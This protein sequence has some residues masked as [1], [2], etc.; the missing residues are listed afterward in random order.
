MTKKKQEKTGGRQP[1]EKMQVVRQVTVTPTTEAHIIA[2]SL[3]RV[4]GQQT[5]AEFAEEL[6][7]T[8]PQLSSYE[9]GRSVPG[10][11]ILLRWVRTNEN[12]LKAMQEMELG[13]TITV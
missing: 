9:S 3:K 13:Q 10:G 7:L 6:G 8:Q 1:R 5:Q 11:D 2:L 4:R 12:L